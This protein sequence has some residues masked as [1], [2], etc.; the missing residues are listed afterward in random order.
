M[1]RAVEAERAVRDLRT[2]APLC[3][4]V[5][6]AFLI[7]AV[8]AIARGVEAAGLL[9][10]CG[11]LVAAVSGA[12][13]QRSVRREIAADRRIRLRGVLCEAVMLPGRMV[14][15]SGT[16][17]GYSYRHDG[18]EITGCTLV[19][20]AT[21]DRYAATGAIIVRCDRDDPPAH[22]VLGAPGRPGREDVHV[23]RQAP[24]PQTL[25]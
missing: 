3:A 11:A 12:W 4:G 22:L 9:W 1:V 8:F 18:G 17:V 16:L 21:A 13:I 14:L 10:A 19:D 24:A 20:A 6:A 7:L 15:A 25:S 5:C 2:G 23:R